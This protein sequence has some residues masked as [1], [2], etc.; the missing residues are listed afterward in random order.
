MIISPPVP[1]PEFKHISIYFP[2]K[3]S[4]QVETGALRL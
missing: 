2:D 1:E 4:R 3:A